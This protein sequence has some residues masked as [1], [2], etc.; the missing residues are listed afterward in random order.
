MNLRRGFSL[1]EI[2][3][4]MLVM[5]M[6][7]TA[8]LQMF[9]WSHLRYREISRAWQLRACLAESRIWLRNKIADAEFAAINTANLSDSLK[10]PEH[11]F[12]SDLKI[13]GHD[14]FTWLIKLVICDDRNQNGRQD[15]DELHNRLFCFRRRS[16]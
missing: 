11:C 3:V 16:A 1:L 7:I 2:T 6:T 13:T 4:V 9:E 8:L 10:L 12:V 5:G 15:P 14:D